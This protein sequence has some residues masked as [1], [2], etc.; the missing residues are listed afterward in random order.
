MASCWV[1][2][3]G[4]AGVFARAGLINLNWLIGRGNWL[5]PPSDAGGDRFLGGGMFLSVSLGRGVDAVRGLKSLDPLTQL[6]HA[7]PFVFA[8]LVGRAGK[9][10]FE[11]ITQ[12]G[13]FGQV[14]VVQEG[15]AQAGLV[16]TKLRFCDSEIS[17]D[18]IAVGAV[19]AR[20]PFQ[21]VQYGT[22]PMV[23]A[24]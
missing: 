5:R 14:G 7:R 22:R 1:M 16:I 19:A 18:A 15:L 11:L 4:D 8:W 6:G 21:G 9:A 13:Q 17:P 2:L 12:C 23:I 3:M 24:R 20:Q 10:G